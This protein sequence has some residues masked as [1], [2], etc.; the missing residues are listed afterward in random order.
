MGIRRGQA[1]GLALSIVIIY[2]L[3]FAGSDSTDFRR[4]TEA[5]LSR[6]RGVLRGSLSDAD[7]TAHTN[8]ELQKILDKQKA[9]SDQATFNGDGDEVAIAGRVSMPKTNDKPKYPS[10]VATGHHDEDEPLDGESMAREELQAIL[11]KSPIIIFSKS[12]C[13]Y[14]KRAKALLLETY[15][16][17]PTPYVVELDLMNKPISRPAR[18]HKLDQEEGEGGDAP[19]PTIGR[20]LQ[21]LLASLTGR[22]TVPNIMINAQSLGGSDDIARMHA[23]GTLADEIKKMGGKRIVS[24]EKSKH[25]EET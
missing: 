6:R 4:T 9:I 20:K 10:G 2:F 12:Y 11:K 1:L 17:S 8:R 25:S 23:D 24:V 18:Q 15:T 3:F 13:P 5:S 22:H 16:I 19:P 7:L 14:S 21:D